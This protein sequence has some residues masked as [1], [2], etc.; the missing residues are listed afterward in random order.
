MT[1]LRRAV[2]RI[3][4]VGAVA[5]AIIVLLWMS[6]SH[7]SEYRALIRASL[8]VR[9]L[10]AELENAA[11]EDIPRLSLERS[12]WIRR[13]QQQRDQLL[14]RGVLVRT[15]LHV[16]DPETF[17]NAVYSN[18]SLMG[19]R[20]PLVNKYTKYHLVVGSGATDLLEV[21]VLRDDIGA[22]TAFRD[23]WVLRQPPPA[24]ETGPVPKEA[25][26]H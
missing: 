7:S 6:R 18:E 25:H 4:S 17:M 22:W 5:L 1:T 11:K 16:P 15:Y 14:S 19:T 20:W 9:A 12:H 23:D 26:G 10:G 24:Q 8:R 21:I 13:V 3:A 2:M